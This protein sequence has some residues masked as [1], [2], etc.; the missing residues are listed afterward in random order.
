L[1]VRQESIGTLFIRTAFDSEFQQ[2][3]LRRFVRKN[4]G[5]AFATVLEAVSNSLKPILSLKYDDLMSLLPYVPS[6]CH[7]FYK[8]FGHSSTNR[9]YPTHDDD[10][11]D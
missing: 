6:D 1:Q 10:D 11:D 9:N 7:V 4:A 5:S 8:S 2:V 3:N